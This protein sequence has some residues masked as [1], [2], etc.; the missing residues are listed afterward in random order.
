MAT[1]RK[2]KP[3]KPL[4]EQL[5]KQA[6]HLATK[7]KRG[8]P[9]QASLR[10]AISTAYYAVF[11]LLVHAAAT[12]FARGPERKK[13]RNLLSRTFDHGEMKA[14]CD[15]YCGSPFPQSVT[16]IWP[17]LIP[18]PKSR[19]GAPPPSP[20]P[21]DLK[22]VAE[23]FRELQAKRHKA[24]YAVD[25]RFTRTQA[26]DEVHRAEAAFAA[27]KNRCARIRWQGYF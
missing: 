8:N 14:T 19:A 25:K 20:I 12:N 27:W 13:L 24:D 18:P 16:G 2:R 10:R 23:A 7:D 1:S 3:F 21:N 15:W 22:L 26:I 9:P 4:H 6:A 17:V 5:L 11:H